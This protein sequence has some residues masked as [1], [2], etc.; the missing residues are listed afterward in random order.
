M[1]NGWQ[2]PW[3]VPLAT[4]E[5]RRP[6]GRAQMCAVPPKPE[7][8]WWQPWGMASPDALATSA[9]SAESPPTFDGGLTAG[10]LQRI[11]MGID[12]ELSAATRAAYASSWR[13]WEGWCRARDQ[14]ALP[15]PRKLWPPT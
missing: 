12:A 10:D 4:G 2:M 1:S 8:V 3:Q 11:A 5:W 13:S 14:V 6:T 15:A 7:G 9:G